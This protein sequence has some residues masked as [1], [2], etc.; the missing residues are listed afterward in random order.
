MGAAGVEAVV[1][2]DGAPSEGA[3]VVRNAGTGM[4]SASKKPKKKIG[5]LVR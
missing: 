1:L 3:G 4:C 2:G 5:E